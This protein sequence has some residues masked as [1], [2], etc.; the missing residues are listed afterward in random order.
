MYH[1]GILYEEA[2]RE[3]KKAFITTVLREQKG[4]LSKA[5]DALHLHRNTLTRAAGEL[6]IDVGA[7]RSTARRP[8]KGIR[9]GYE[10]KTG[11][12]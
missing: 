3:F 7:L 5:G 1:S 4:N 2:L 8:P 9:P 11:S 12:R 10:R 6:G